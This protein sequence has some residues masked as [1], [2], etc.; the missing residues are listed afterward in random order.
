MAERK[1]IQD[2]IT[3]RIVAM[4]DEGTVPWRPHHNCRSARP[5]LNISGRRYRGVNA[6]MTWAVSLEKGYESPHWLTFNQARE[7]GGCVR[8]GE[9]GT[10]V[11]YYGQGVGK[12]DD[13]N[14]D[15]SRRFAFAKGYTVFNVEQIDGI[16]PAKLP[17]E[18]N[19]T[20]RWEHSPIESAI[21]IIDGFDGPGFVEA[22]VTPH[23]TPLT[24]TV[25][26]PPMD[27]FDSS[28]AYY[29]VYFHELI[30]STGHESRLARELTG[31][32]SDS[33]YGKEEL[34]AEFGAS[35]LCAEAGIV[36]EV[37]EN[38]AAYIDAWRKVIKADKTLIMTAASAAQKAVDCVMASK[39][40]TVDA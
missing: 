11:V 2:K 18:I 25:T 6:F 40:E 13:G 32:K 39:L 27:R 1:T 15:P 20:E 12:D 36:A 14:K 23:Y 29:A 34:I 38:N 9:K 28:E 37:I 33:S 35:F 31:D 17:A 4:L 26:M 22:A 19:A 21:E 16:D 10:P 8:K 3:D 30:H 7:L 24:D 5:G